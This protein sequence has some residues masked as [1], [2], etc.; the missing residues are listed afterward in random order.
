[1]KKRIIQSKSKNEQVYDY[2]H[3]QILHGEL[4]PGSRI[5]ID[6]IADELGVSHIPIREAIFRLK[7]DGFISFEPHIGAKVTELE[8][9]EISEVFQVLEAMEVISGRA[10]CERITSKD[11]A[12]LEKLMKEMTSVTGDP[13][14]WS[15]HNKDFHQY[16]CEIAETG[17]INKVLREALDHWDRLRHYY[18]QEVSAKRVAFAQAEHKELFEALKAQ[19]A[20]RFEAVIRKHNQES[21]QAYICHLEKIGELANA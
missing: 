20:D 1:M 15:I 8:A 3:S 4:A 2:L 11:I 16:I 5:I 10:A 7:A 18:L 13:N 14:Q 6:Q 21:L 17:L 19:D 12:W 9:K